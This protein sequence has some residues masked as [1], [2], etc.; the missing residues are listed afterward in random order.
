MSPFTN[1]YLTLWSPKCFVVVSMNPFERNWCE[2][3]CHILYL[4]LGFRNPRC[5]SI[6]RFA[7]RIFAVFYFWGYFESIYHS[8]S[9]SLVS[10]MFCRSFY[11]SIWEKLMRNDMPHP[12][13]IPR[14]PKSTLLVNL[15]LRVAHFR[16]F[17]RLFR[18]YFAIFIYG[19]NR[20]SEP[21]RHS[22]S[23]DIIDMPHPYTLT[24]SLEV[25]VPNVKNCL[26]GF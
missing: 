25:G 11:R 10:K 21:S 15:S 14:I 26:K 20:F 12:V 7:W 16:V 8:I 4:F 22:A 24:S 6:F 18:V 2:M 9:Y 23:I 1:Q 3:L 5:W 13:F 19:N 17:S